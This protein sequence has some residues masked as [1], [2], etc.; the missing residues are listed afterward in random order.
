MEHQPTNGLH[1][2]KHDDTTHE[3]Q[4]HS[5]QLDEEVPIEQYFTIPSAPDARTDFA[6]PAERETQPNN[7]QIEEGIRE[8][9]DAFRAYLQLPDIDP[10]RHDLLQTF[11]EF[12]I[13][14]FV[15]MD[16]LLDELTDIRAWTDAINEVASR[17]GIDGMISLDRVKIEAVAH[18]TWDIVEIGGR[19]YV[20]AK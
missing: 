2:E 8:H 19:L 5:A 6:L 7:P 20:F 17:C 13:D 16:A 14:T 9:G 15:S 3:Q 12:Y 4:I 11:H 18:E 10:H 1:H